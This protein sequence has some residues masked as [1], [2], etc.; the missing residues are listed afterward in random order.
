MPKYTIQNKK[1]RDRQF[2][3]AIKQTGSPKEAAKIVGNIGS[4]GGKDLENVAAVMG[5]KR[6]KQVNEPILEAML[7]SG[8]TAKKIAEKVDELLNDEN[9]IAIDKGVTQALKVGVGGGYSPEK[10]LNVN[11]DINEKE[12]AE[13]KK[14]LETI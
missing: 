7:Q 2:L 5:T 13:A 4:Q 3:E 10:H 12:R 9:P 11:I 14:A 1:M 8:V 6:L